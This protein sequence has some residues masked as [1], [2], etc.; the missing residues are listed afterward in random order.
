MKRIAFIISAIILMTS[1]TQEDTVNSG[2]GTLILDISRENVPQVA[3]TR[4]IS[5]TLAI[6]ILCPDGS[7]YQEYPAGSV[8]NKIT[9]DAGVLYTVKAFTPNQQT[10]QTA[11]NGLGEACYYGETTVSAGVDEV[12]VCSYRVPMTNYAVTF[13]LPEYFDQLF[14]AYGLSLHTQGRDV[15]LQQAETKAYFTVD[16][17]GF[18]YQLQ[19]TNND[20]KTSRHSVVEYPE[21]AVG[22]LYNIRYIYV[23]DFN[24]G[25]IDIDITDN[26]EKEDVD[27]TI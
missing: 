10:W 19:A 26:T 11:N 16:D 22:K 18:S 3:G 6:Q 23:T 15:T 17:Q 12:T 25:G 27:I 20:G 24:S 4:A 5:S 7:I 13:T 21:V 8:P 2:K 9:L 1:C 14:T